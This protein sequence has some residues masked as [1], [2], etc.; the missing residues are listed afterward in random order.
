MW[1]ATQ[2]VW[3]TTAP[4]AAAPVRGT[5]GAEAPGVAG[6]GDADVLGVLLDAGGV[7]VFVV[8]VVAGF[9]TVVPTLSRPFIPLAA[10]PATG[11]RYPYWPCFANLTTSVADAPGASG[12]VA[13]PAHPFAAALV[14]DAEHTLN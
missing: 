2:T 7:V 5:L 10:W 12:F 4:A 14:V 6:A 13:V 3:N 9:A 8:V 1:Q 11:E